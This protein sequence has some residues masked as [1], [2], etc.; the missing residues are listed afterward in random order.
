[1]ERASQ[2]HERERRNQ[3]EREREGTERVF[4]SSIRFFILFYFWYF[5]YFEKKEEKDFGLIS[6]TF[7]FS[8]L[9]PNERLKGNIY[10]V[11]VAYKTK[12][13]F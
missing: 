8:K 9:A 6:T 2:T 11:F 12:Q 7:G 13:T 1:M 3:R 4:Q 10:F 5:G